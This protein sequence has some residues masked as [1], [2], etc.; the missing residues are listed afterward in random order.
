MK[1]WPSPSLLAYL[2]A[3][4]GSHENFLNDL[5]SSLGL[6]ETME[7]VGSTGPLVARPTISPILLSSSHL[8]NST[9]HRHCDFLLWGLRAYLEA[10]S[11]FSPPVGFGPKRVG[12]RVQVCPTPPTGLELQLQTPSLPSRPECLFSSLSAQGELVVVP[13]S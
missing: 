13:T 1:L 8:L 3:P 7:W 4:M 10:S 12:A 11:I 2:R 5:P 9:G 6:Q